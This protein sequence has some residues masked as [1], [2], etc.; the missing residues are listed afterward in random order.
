LPMFQVA[1]LVRD[2]DILLLAREQASM[3]L[4]PSS[5]ELVEHSWEWTTL[6]NFIQNRYPGVQEWL[7][8]R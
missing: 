2:V 7:M 5:G 3:F 4:E 6:M 8:I 1:S